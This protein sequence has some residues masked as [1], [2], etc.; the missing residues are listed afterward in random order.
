MVTERQKL[1]DLDPILTGG[2]LKPVLMM[3]LQL[4]KHTL[5]AYTGECLGHPSSPESPLH[6]S[7]HSVHGGDIVN[8]Q[9][10]NVCTVLHIDP[11]KAAVQAC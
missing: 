2:P 3:T 11:L 9:L 4:S 8:Y 7:R 1:I 10:S 6:C 5:N